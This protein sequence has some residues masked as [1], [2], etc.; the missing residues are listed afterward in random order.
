MGITKEQ[1]VKAQQI[2]LQFIESTKAALKRFILDKHVELDQELT[3]KIQALINV[4]QEEHKVV[5]LLDNEVGIQDSP[6]G[7]IINFMG[8]RAP[9]HYL[10]CDGSIYNIAD[11]PV[12]ANHFLEQFE[13][14]NYF[15]GDGE[16][17]FAVP[18]LRGEFLRGSGT[19]E[20][21][22]GSGEEVGVHQDATEIPHINRRTY[23]NGTSLLWFDGLKMSKNNDFA[24]K[25]QDVS[26]RQLPSQGQI[27]QGTFSASTNNN[28][29]S[30]W[31]MQ[32]ASTSFT[33]RPT[34]TSVLF[35]IKYEPSYCMQI[36]MDTNQYPAIGEEVRV[37]T[38]IDGNPLYR[39][40]FYVDNLLAATSIDAS[41][42]NIDKVIYLGG[43]FCEETGRLST[44]SM[45]YANLNY[46]A[47]LEQ[48]VDT[49][50]DIKSKQ[51]W[52]GV[53]KTYI[54]CQAYI[55]VEYTKNDQLLN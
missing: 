23:P 37:G 46:G 6:V 13:M 50:Y 52:L 24:P 7:S 42:L 5:Q 9:S 18:D 41:Q 15:G 35:C 26:F 2:T 38:W 55:K 27:W 45:F 30:G 14:V 44:T 39:S 8:T 11:Y 48:H 54:G 51:I 40:I 12:L 32:F 4:Y 49:Y 53:G 3:A 20:R 19:A 22:T 43:T 47:S 1:L 10:I 17:T 34:N 29:S 25:N 36:G 16:T 21:N 31:N 28:A 33:S